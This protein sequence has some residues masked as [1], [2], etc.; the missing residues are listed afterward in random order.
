MAMASRAV[1]LA[2]RSRRST[3]LAADAGRAGPGQRRAYRGVVEVLRGPDR[4]DRRQSPADWRPISWAWCRRRWAAGA[5]A[6]QEA[7]RAQAIVSRTY[8]LRNL[9]RWRAQGFDLYASVADQVYG[10]VAS[11][12][13][14]GRAA[15]DATRGQVLTYGGAPIDAFFYSTCG[16]RTADGTEVFARRTGPTCVG[17][18]HGR[19]RHGLLQHLAAIPLAR[20][21][22]RRSAPR[23]TAAHAAAPAPGTAAPTR[24][25]ARCATSG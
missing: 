9:R 23:H 15:V 4:P 5:S 19:G 1:R 24:R 18:R 16:G 17:L 22:D 8:A 2:R 12:T 13:P 14:E 11:E 6:E 20:G 25:S 21:V 7:L 10:G 3:S